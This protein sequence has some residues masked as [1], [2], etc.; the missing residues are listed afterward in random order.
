MHVKQ[1]HIKRMHIICSEMHDHKYVP[2]HKY[3]QIW[4]VIVCVEMNVHR[5]I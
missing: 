1:M 2:E 5:R 3:V 4:K